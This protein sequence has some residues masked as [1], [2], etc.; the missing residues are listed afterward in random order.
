MKIS[1]LVPT[2]G[3]TGGIKVIFEYANRLVE[4]GH[5]V[6]LVYP[7]VLPIKP[8]LGD[9]LLGFLKRIRRATLRLLGVDGATSFPL[10]SRVKV[11]RLPNLSAELVPDA[12][13]YIAT[14]NE[15]ADWLAAYPNSKGRKFY[16]IQDYETWSRDYQEVDATWRLPLHL[17]V[18]APW[19]RELAKKKFNLPEP[20]MV[21]N[22][23]DFKVFNNQSPKKYGD[24]IRVLMMYHPLPKKGF[25][26]GLTAF[27]LAQ[28]K[29]QDLELVIFGAYRP[30]RQI[31]KNYK[32]YYRPKLEQLKDIY[33]S[34]DIFLWPSRFE[35]FGLPPMEAMA[36]RCVV[37]ST[38][39]GAIREYAIDQETT[40]IV[41]PDNPVKMAQAL[42]NLACDKSKLSLLSEQAYIKIQD[43]SWNNSI[44]QMEKI[45]TDNLIA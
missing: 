19:L 5:Q 33:N 23:V 22:G 9:L 34:A 30:S 13:A 26:D 14:A 12:D 42:V 18:I 24:K 8:S 10:D 44:D 7:Y 2:T 21:L 41:P 38:D 11:I 28:E 27:N 29:Y 36:C 15:T 6:S 4:R 39:T 32:F 43:F 40:I 25:I 3:L 20:D 45:L 16:F 37:I 17:I 1:F 35:G 31:L